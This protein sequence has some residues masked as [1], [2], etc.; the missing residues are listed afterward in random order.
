MTAGFAADGYN[1]R[2]DWEGTHDERGHKTGPGRKD[3][4]HKQKAL[5]SVGADELLQTITL[6]ITH[7]RKQKDKEAAVSCKRAD[8][9][10][11]KLDEYKDSVEQS[12]RWL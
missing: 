11:L 6:L 2:E 10:K 4:L 3:R 8:I 9:L 7:Q 5:Q 1:L 12:D